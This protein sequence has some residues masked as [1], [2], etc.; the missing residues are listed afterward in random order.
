MI[1]EA[2][3]EWV[4][5]VESEAEGIDTT[6][7]S[8]TQQRRCK[9]HSVQNVLSLSSRLTVTSHIVPIRIDDRCSTVYTAG[10]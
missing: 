1:C 9:R 10:H 7:S 2:E 8:D 5:S 6:L 3:T 4:Y